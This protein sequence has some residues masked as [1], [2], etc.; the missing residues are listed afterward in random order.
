MNSQKS[1]RVV[2]TGLGVVAPNAVGVSAFA[3]ALQQGTSGIRF[4][5]QLADL[6]F[7]CQVAGTPQVTQEQTDQYLTPLQQRGFKAS[8][9]LYG[10]IAGKQAFE[11]AGLSIAPKEQALEDFG[12]IFGTGQS[13]G[14]KFREAIHLIDDG[15]VRRL[16]STSVIQTMSSGI[17]AWLAGE[18]GA[19]NMVTS[20]SSACSTGTEALIMGYERIAAGKAR[21]MLV[22][23]TSDSGP[24]IWGGFDAMRILPIHYNENPEQASRPFAADA[25]GFVPG[26]G[27]GAILLESLESALDRGARIYCEVLGGAINAGGH[28]GDGSMTAPNGAAVQKVIRQSL[29]DAGI[30]ASE[31]DAINGHVTATG[32][33]AYEVMNWS[34]AFD[35][36][37]TDFP[38]MNSFKSSIGH[39]LAAAGSIELVGSI[40]Q[41][42]EQ[43]IFKN[44]NLNVLHPEIS[45]LVDPAKIPNQTIPTKIDLLLKA[46]FGFGDVN[47]CAVLAR[48]KD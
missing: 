28:R 22:G 27:A 34:K 39:C 42:Q 44:N 36:S 20:N 24:Y 37:G 14:E 3:K 40:L 35:R 32:K 21:Q 17:S 18:L 10:I 1:G 33:D 46:S 30:D 11:D 43:H 2:V 6:N 26:S 12:I 16:G 15:K 9:M 45:E 48:F 41:I 7:G 23:S 38:F 4:Q 29:K 47:A 25:A 31:V 19:G 5:Q 13:G 8:G